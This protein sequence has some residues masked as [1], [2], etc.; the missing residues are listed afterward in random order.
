M[1]KI[2]LIIVLAIG[3]KPAPA[4]ADPITAAITAVQAFAATSAVAAFVV[5][6]GVSLA[7]SA[8]ASVLRGKPAAARRPGI[9][10]EFTTTGSDNPQ[11]FILGRYATGGNMATPPYSHPN[12]GNVPNKYLTYVVD[13]SDVPG[14]TLSRVIVGGN[15]VDDLQASA[16]D[17]D[18]EGMFVDGAPHLFMTY[19]DGS[20]TAADAYMMAN[21]STDSE[22]PWAADM[23]GTGLSYAVITFKYNRELLNTPPG[24]RFECDGVPLYDPRADSTV[25]GTGAQ[26]WDDPATWAQT[27]N[28]AVMIYNILRGIALPDGSAWGGR[29]AA[30]DLP[31]D[32]WFAAMNECDQSIALAGGGTEPQYRAGYEVSLDMAPADVIDE[33]AK[34][35]SGEVVEMGG[36]YKMRVGAPALPVYFFTDDDVV[37]DEP[38][39][40]LP[41]PGLDSVSNA[42]HASYP[43][44]GALWE[45]TPAPSRYN[46]AWEAEDG[47]RRLAVTV[48]LPAAPYDAQVQRLMQAWINDDRRFRRHSLV[49]PPDAAML[50]PLD[51]AAW[52][53]ARNGYAAKVFEIAELSDDLTTCLQSIAMRERDSGDFVWTAA[54]DEVAI[55][56]PSTGVPTPPA[57]YVPAWNVSPAA[58]VDDNGTD[59]RPGLLLTW[60]GS[61]M[62]DCSALEYAVRPV[63]QVDLVAQ[64]STTD[65]LA[66]QFLISAGIVA[67]VGYEAQARLVSDRDVIWSAWNAAT[68]PNVQFGADD[69]SQA[70]WDQVAAQADAVLATFKAGDF[71]QANQALAT[72]AAN[73]DKL[74]ELSMLGQLSGDLEMRKLGD[75]LAIATQQ[76]TA[77][78][79]EADQAVAQLKIDLAAGVA[80]NVALI[81]VEQTA[82]ADGD[83][84]NATN[85]TA[86]AASVA[87]L[88]GD[89]TASL[90]QQAEATADLEG[91]ASAGYLLQAQAGG[92]VSLLQLIAADGS[93]TSAS[94][95]RLSAEFIILDGSVSASHMMAGEVLVNIGLNVGGIDTD[96]KTGSGAEIDAQGNFFVGDYDAGRYLEFSKSTGALT[97]VGKFIRIENIEDLTPALPTFPKQVQV[98]RNSISFAAREAGLV[99][100]TLV[101]GGG[102][103]GATSTTEDNNDGGAMGG[104][105][106]GVVIDILT[107]VAEG[108]SFS[109]VIGAGGASVSGYEVGNIS[110]SWTDGLPGSGSTLTRVSNGRVLAAS[111]G[112]AGEGLRGNNSLA[113]GAGGA[114]SGGLFNFAGGRGGNA[115]QTDINV[116]TAGGLVD[117]DGTAFGI[118]GLDY[119][120]SGWES[121]PTPPPVEGE[122]TVV[123]N[124]VAEVIAA[125]DAAGDGGGGSVAQGYTHET[126]SGNS[127]Y[128]YS[129][130]ISAAGLDGVL[131]V[132]YFGDQSS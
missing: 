102:S 82:R 117:F 34:A 70:V 107:D 18:L 74:T 53:S 58:V 57:R 123:D 132:E 17:H 81:Q 130:A 4:A 122:V 66:G 98:L 60:D 99:R 68:A 111:G 40:L 84:A 64:G 9:K 127:V 45:T 131:I 51:T 6:I 73:A 16:G 31:L 109:L 93:G 115:Q 61:D 10:T 52:T 44:P 80:G 43:A 29:V 47:D 106:A 110:P 27:D 104:G 56:W 108:E 118:N 105:A 20:Q 30:A 54:D 28:P 42:I 22:R 112:G 13:V 120:F 87:T 95:A 15:Y 2:F 63:G 78:I 96:E 41:Y 88:D 14:V 35:C 69:M 11:S 89:I 77:D 94:I 23:L 24:V 119:L 39:Q 113:G 55:I 36:V 3:I 5:R 12:S 125:R 126:G 129:V 50:E 49:L 71:A 46:A 65:L 124:S 91:N 100:L 86:L 19:H 32:T 33:L 103:G 90:I 26:R 75:S 48:P 37:T 7:L 8:V 101:G 62:G 21:Y 114:A 25:G 38:D 79:S 97:L 116:P 83:V 121:P 59:R 67:G 85:I 92:E 72:V 1:K 128:K 76:L